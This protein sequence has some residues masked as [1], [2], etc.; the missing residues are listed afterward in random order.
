MTH[1]TGASFVVPVG[2]SPIL[3]YAES[4]SRKATESGR[5]LSQGRVTCNRPG[6]T[7]RLRKTFEKPA[8]ASRGV[9]GYPKACNGGGAADCTS[10]RFR[11][12]NGEGVVIRSFNHSSLSHS[13]RYKICWAVHKET[14]F[15]SNRLPDL[16]R[17]PLPPL[18]HCE[19]MQDPLSFS[20]L[21]A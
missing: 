9:A 19:R 3:P 5:D 14:V 15:R 18:L 16:M 20:R 7:P 11:S 17:G 6:T 10:L 21:A 4:S 1:A 2:W 8:C 12:D 13:C